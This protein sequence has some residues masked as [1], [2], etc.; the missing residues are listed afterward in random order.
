[1]STGTI[2]QGTLIK[3]RRDGQVDTLISAGKS[4]PLFNSGIP[5]VFS[6]LGNIMELVNSGLESEFLNIKPSV[7]CAKDLIAGGDIIASGEGTGDPGISYD[8][9]KTWRIAA[10]AGFTWGSNDVVAAGTI[11]MIKFVAGPNI[12]LQTDAALKAIKI[13]ATGGSNMTYPGEG[14]PVS[15]GSAWGASI[16]NNSANWNTAFGW[17]NHANAGYAPLLNP[18]FTGQVAIGVSTLD[19]ASVKLQINGGQLVVD[20]WIAGSTAKDCLELY[21]DKDAATGLKIQSNGN[22]LIG[23]LASLGNSNRL[24]VSGGTI[25]ADSPGGA[26]RL[27]S[28]LGILQ[29]NDLGLWWGGADFKI[30]DWDTGTKGIS[31]N[32]TTGTVTRG[33]IGVVHSGIAGILSETLVSSVSGRKAI[34]LYNDGSNNIKLDAYDYGTS[35]ALNIQLGGNGGNIYI[36]SGHILH[37]TASNAALAG[38]TGQVIYHS[39]NPGI[40]LQNTSGY[41]LQYMSGANLRWYNGAERMELTNAGTLRVTG[42]VIAAYE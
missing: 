37:G 7:T 41:Y 10:D 42:D 28:S 15:T 29:T 14:I 9:F 13:S 22:V 5:D 4:L 19:H 40:S 23:R 2:R 3:K 34:Y 38:V 26:I 20:G 21:G 24:Q 27:T 32:T 30:A 11:D 36:P 31:I 16:A 12:T 33:T 17:G 8:S 25:L 39:S 1:M 6:L 18:V 35:S